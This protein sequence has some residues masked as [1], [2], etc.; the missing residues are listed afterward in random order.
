MRI[1]FYDFEV[2]RKLW[3]VVFEDCEI[4][5]NEKMVI[6]NTKL[7]KK[8]VIVND[9]DELK[10]FYEEN[11]EQIF[12]GYNSRMYD[13][14]IFKGILQDISP[15]SISKAIIEEEKKGYS[16]VPNCDKY[17]LNNFD[18][19]TGFHSLKQ[20]EG[21]MGSR[22]KESSIPF[23]IKRELTPDEIEE[24]I[25]Y[26]THDV[27]QTIKVFENRS[28]EFFAQLKLIEMFNL[29][30]N[31]IN[32]TKAQLTA[33][34][35]NAEAKEYNDEFNITIPNN[36]QIKKYKHIVDWYRDK[37]NLSYEKELNVEVA[38]IPHTFAWGGLHGS[39]DN[40]CGEGIILCADV[41]SLY[42]SIMLEYGYVSRSILEPE[43]FREIRDKRIQYKKEKNPLQAP[44]KI[45]INAMYGTMKDKHNPNYDPLMANNVCIAG[46][47]LILD[48]IEHVEPYAELL[49]TNT[50]GIYLM[51]DS[52]ETVQKI[53]EIAT[54][55]EQRTRLTLEWDIHDKIYQKDVNNYILI[56]ND[57]KY[58]SKGAYVKQLK[59]IDYDLPI[60][61]KAL[62]NYF[63]YNKSIEET[64]N[65]C[66]KLIEFQKIV[67][68]SNLYSHALYGNKKLNEKV[69][70]V[71][72]ST[73]NKAPGVFKVKG[74]DKVEKIANTPEHCFINNEDITNETI[75]EYLDKQYY[76]KVAK[77]RLN[78]FFN[79]KKKASKKPSSGIK[80]INA[81]LL[82]EV[83]N[84]YEE[85]E[86]STFT[87]FLANLIEEVSINKTQLE[88]LIKLNYFPDYGYNL[89]LLNIYKEFSLKYKRTYAK[90]TKLM[91]I[92]ELKEYES[93][94]ADEKIPIKEQLAFE[95]EVMRTLKS[96]YDLPKQYIYIIDCDTTYSPKLKCYC[97]A[98]G[99]T[100]IMK[101]EKRTYNKN[102]IKKGDIIRIIRSHPA[103]RKKKEGDDWVVVEGEKDWWIDSYEIV[104][105]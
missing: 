64:I 60:I 34:I 77:D 27:E 45:A 40:Y 65:E 22:I 44:L 4:T 7:L 96:T 5:Y 99:K 87:D 67:K 54:E 47:L 56:D 48:L 86:F 105:F 50:D 104:N 68:I 51:V 57:G 2:F 28:E 21:F 42:P 17:P 80:G 73:D 23:D 15:Y 69:L 98:N 59:K 14:F 38:G 46:Q 91:R 62:V 90:K 71:F 25:A 100:A 95:L 72:A 79:P 43:L 39:R 53:K 36:L 55:W 13:Q 81:I 61:N 20:L 3:L 18:I 8:T 94:V 74:K 78:D 31:M 97:L 92:N 89:K 52:M 85:H 9:N 82:E 75:P 76:I 37:K 102:K 12:C 84:F 6:T 101:V 29:P 33:R 35:L 30:V 70:R 11:K 83:V 58:K 49:Q 66:D 88:T 26:C 24:T 32:N 63:I 41:A 93:T 10:R 103:P 1:I 16:V 19:S